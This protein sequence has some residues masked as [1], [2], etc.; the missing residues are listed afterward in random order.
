MLQIGDLC[1]SS[2]CSRVC[3]Q[4]NNKIFWTCFPQLG[5]WFNQL[6]CVPIVWLIS[7]SIFACS[8]NPDRTLYYSPHFHLF[9][10]FFLRKVA[11]MNYTDIR[12]NYRI[13]CILKDLT[14]QWEK[15]KCMKLI[16]KRKRND[17]RN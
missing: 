12:N 6:S 10:H 15:Q 8:I 16:N 5:G 13:N 9:I 17:N 2:E 14:I 4:H 7:K 1:Q 3:S 11:I